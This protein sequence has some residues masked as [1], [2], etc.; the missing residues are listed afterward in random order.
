MNPTQSFRSEIH[1]AIAT[2]TLARPDRLNALTFDVYREL[3]AWFGNLAG[4]SEVRCVILRGE[5]DAFC[6]GGDVK[7][8]IGPLLQYDMRQTLDFTRLTGRLVPGTINNRISYL[9]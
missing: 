8:I 2:V 5:G 6:S 1:D 9:V 7:D 3:T 4:N